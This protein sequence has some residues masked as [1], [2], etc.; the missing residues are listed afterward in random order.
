MQMT[1]NAR[2]CFVPSQSTTYLGFVQVRAAAALHVR[3]E[4][5]VTGA[6]V[7]LSVDKSL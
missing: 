7:C 1:S 6:A 2:A 4:R 5:N 3:L